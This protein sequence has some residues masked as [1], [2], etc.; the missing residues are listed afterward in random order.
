MAAEEAKT[1]TPVT[2]EKKGKSKG[3]TGDH[4]KA[5]APAK[6]KSKAHA[7]QEAQRGV[8]PDDA[9]AAIPS[10]PGAGSNDVIR[11]R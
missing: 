6:S 5:E 9:D 3:K 4:K 7:E 10:W 8:E 2:S 1:E 11:T